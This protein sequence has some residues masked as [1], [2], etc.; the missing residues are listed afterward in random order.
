MKSYELTCLISPDL[1]EEELKQLEEKVASFIREEEGI[2]NGTSLVVRKALS[3]PVK[4][5]HSAYLAMINFQLNPEKIENLEAKLK[6]E[7]QV[8]RYLVTVKPPVKEM[9]AITR[10]PATIKSAPKKTMEKVELKEIEKKLEEILE[11]EP[12]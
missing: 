7:N 6:K 4:K 3:Y 11:D 8:L 2:L 10:R 12:K 5:K 1:S 9:A